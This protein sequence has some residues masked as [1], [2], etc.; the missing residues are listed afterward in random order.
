MTPMRPKTKIVCTLG[1]STASEDTLRTMV[2]AGMSIARLNFSHGALEE[3]KAAVNMVR[4]VSDALGIPVGIMVDVPGAKY[5]TGPLGT[6][7]VNL[8]DGERFT[9]T[10]RDIIGNQEI[11]AV[12]PPGIHRD[13]TVGHPIML[14][15][16]FLE[17]KTIAINDQ[18][19]ECAVV[20]GGR[21]TER[22]GVATPGRA[23]SQPF[24]SEQAMRAMEFAAAEKVDFVALSMVTRNTHVFRAREILES[25]GMKPFIISKIERADAIDRLDSILE[26][27]DG[28]M[29]ARGDMGVEV[30]LAQVPVI[31]KKLI[32][33]SNEYGKPVITATQMLESMVRSPVPTRAEVTDVANA[34]Y[35]G[36]DA[37]ML[38]GETSVGQYPVQ[39]V[40]VMAEVALEAEA[41]LPYDRILVEKRAHI[42]GR[43]DDAIAY[44]AVRTAS[45]INAGLIVAF[46]ESG[47]TAG[48]VSRYRPRQHIL[49]LTPSPEGRRRLTL[50]WG[51]TPV[52]VERIDSV[53]DFFEVGDQAATKFA[54]LPAGTQIVLVAGLPIGVPGGTNLLR[55]L[56]TSG[57]KVD[58][59]FFKVAG[60]QPA[61]KG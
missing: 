36:T 57:K 27:S 55:V 30:R 31:Q 44:D 53:D 42:V 22:R 32:S 8:K 58:S 34:I 46:T 35:D 16:G 48:R 4:K 5:R 52:M 6:G 2:Q 15:D 14:D 1:P 39:A 21:L 61:S 28:I 59:G 12:A 45:Q 17:L 19:V 49:A 41:A 11:V 43:V 7:V 51:V 13:A 56:S 38:S 26:A 20:R 24:P 37:I 47:S 23:P 25:K 54:D 33:K 29:V 10:S 50:R 18:D 9:L 60:K 3:H 40:K